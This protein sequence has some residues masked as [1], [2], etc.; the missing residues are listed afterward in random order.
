MLWVLF[1]AGLFLTL[2]MP[3]VLPTLQVHYF[4]PF[5]VLCLYRLPLR[6]ALWFA[7][8]SGL[9][10]DLLSAQQR[11]GIVSL[12]FFLSLYLLSF[13]KQAL[14]EDSYSTL[15]IM[16]FLFSFVSALLY[17]PLLILFDKPLPLSPTFLAGNLLLMPFIDSCY[18]FLFYTLP[19]LLFGTPQKKG[20]DY[21][22]NR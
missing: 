15:P 16:T 6:R 21:F 11:F 17:F 19:T 12:N 18:C 13:L 3:T 9:L 22:L 4:P 14:F 20:Q 5:L 2:T 10:F 7:T 1:L 8:L